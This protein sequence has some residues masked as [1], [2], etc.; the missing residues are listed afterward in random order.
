MHEI[1][2]IWIFNNSDFVSEENDDWW[3]WIWWCSLFI[4]DSGVDD[5]QPIESTRDTK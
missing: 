1:R 5:N 3:L 2:E 4:N